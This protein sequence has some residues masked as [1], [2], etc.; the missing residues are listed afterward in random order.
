MNIRV[1]WSNLDYTATLTSMNFNELNKNLNARFG[2]MK[3]FSLVPKSVTLNQIHSRIVKNA[4]QDDS[5]DLGT[6]KNIHAKK[7]GSLIKKIY[8]YGNGMSI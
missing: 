3:K 4:A 7:F 8:N 1:G 6:H 5:V 2:G